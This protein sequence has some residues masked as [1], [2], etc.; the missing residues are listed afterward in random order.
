VDA[1]PGVANHGNDAW[2]PLVDTKGISVRE[3]IDSGDAVLAR[4]VKR[5]V[6]SLDDPNGV[7]SAF[8]SFASA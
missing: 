7:I 3:L 4:S 2:A 5:L 8:N 1:L 6:E